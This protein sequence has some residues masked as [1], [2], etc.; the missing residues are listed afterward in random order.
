M[1]GA[2]SWRRPLA[3]AAAVS[4]ALLLIT[5]THVPK[6]PGVLQTSHDKS[7]HF[8]A[9]A[10]LAFLFYLAAV[11]QWPRRGGMPLWVVLVGAV[12]AAADEISQPYFGRSSD[13]LDFRADMIGLIA[14]VLLAAIGRRLVKRILRRRQ[15]PRP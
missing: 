14:G 7:L 5:L 15:T 3:W 1:T 8:I 10:V 12:F 6:P 2:G 11:T 9:Y 13:V 4:W